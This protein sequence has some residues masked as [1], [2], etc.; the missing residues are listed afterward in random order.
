MRSTVRNSTILL[1]GLILCLPLG[2]AAAAGDAAAGE[3]KSLVCGACHGQEGMSNNPMWPH[4]AGQQEAYLA[5]QIKA[6]RDS[7]RVEPTMI[8]FVANLSDDDILDLAAYYAGLP[9]GS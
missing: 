4:L 6:F 7:N 1:V 2:S 5:K 8:G 9:A 3:Q